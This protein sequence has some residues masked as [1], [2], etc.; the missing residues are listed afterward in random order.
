MS[1]GGNAPSYRWIEES[2]VT[3]KTG[4]DGN[5]E[6]TKLEMIVNDRKDIIEVNDSVLLYSDDIET[7]EK[8]VHSKLDTFVARIEKMW[9]EP[10]PAAGKR[11]KNRKGGKA[12]EKEYSEERKMRMKIRAR[13]YF[14]VRHNPSLIESCYKQLY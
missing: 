1:F 4:K 6:Y 5:T 8:V 12:D 9:E 14:K 2:K 7:H 10:A 3:S 13:W 11:D